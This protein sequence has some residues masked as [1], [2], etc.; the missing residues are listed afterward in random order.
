MRRH[1]ARQRLDLPPG[2]SSRQE[3]PGKVTSRSLT[4]SPGIRQLLTGEHLLAADRSRIGFDPRSRYAA[5]NLAPQS[6]QLGLESIKFDAR[7]LTISEASARTARP[8]S[9]SPGTTGLPS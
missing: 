1:D 6:A 5:T 4:D 9:G 3:P 7:T 8:P 2:T